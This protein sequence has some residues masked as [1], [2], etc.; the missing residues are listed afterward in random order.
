MAGDWI[1]MRSNLWDDP[2]VSRICDLT[3]TSEGPVIGALYWLWST[4][5]QHTEDGFMPG[6]TLRQIDR[7]TGLSGF[8]AAL[9]EIGWLVDGEAGVIIVKFEEH[10]GE[11]AK[12]RCQTAKRVA[13]HRAGNADVTQGALQTEGKSVTG[14]LAREEK[15]KSNT[16][17]SLRSGETRARRAV[18]ES[19][20]PEVLVSA[21]FDAKTA[22]EFIAH[23]ASQ[24]APLT[25]R[26]WT[27][28]QRE[29][30]K[31]GWSCLQA[32]EKVM[33]KGWKGF[34]AKYVQGE[35]PMSRAPPESFRAQELR[36]AEQRVAQ[37]T[38][39]LLGRRQPQPTQDVLDV[40][41]RQLD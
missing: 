37:L 10:N 31:A 35:S 14:A 13:N 24:K 25:Q 18:P 38:G 3:D 9:V 20:D 17:P 32:A 36:I 6:L 22:A 12:K 23:K 39:G 8:A 28:H 15:E 21:G 5:D 33:A 26:A 27:D 16:S 7:K 40:T 34:E 41:P 4:A 30:V 1:K 2:R 19:I 11:S 29:S